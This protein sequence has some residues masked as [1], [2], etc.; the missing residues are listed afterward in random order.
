MRKIHNPV[1]VIEV[2]KFTCLKFL[3]I[4]EC[5]VNEL[6]LCFLRFRDQ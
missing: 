5:F 1:Q 6:D 4:A 3:K 2:N